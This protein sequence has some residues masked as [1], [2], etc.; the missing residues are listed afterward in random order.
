[1]VQKLKTE[2]EEQREKEVE[3]KKYEPYVIPERF[4]RWIP[5]EPNRTVVCMYAVT[6]YPLPKYWEYTITTSSTGDKE[7]GYIIRGS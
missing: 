7:V 4:G 6:P 3:P 1:M 2:Q 5:F